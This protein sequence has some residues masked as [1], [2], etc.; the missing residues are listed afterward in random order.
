MLCFFGQ[1][2]KI[3]RGEEALGLMQSRAGVTAES[4]VQLKQALDTIMSDPAGGGDE[5]RQAS[6][7]VCCLPPCAFSFE[8]NLGTGSVVY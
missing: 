3:Y 4:L 6:V 1:A 2:H 7:M 5:V 8:R